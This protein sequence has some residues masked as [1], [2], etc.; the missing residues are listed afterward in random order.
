[1]EL[2]TAFRATVTFNRDVFIAGTATSIIIHFLLVDGQVMAVAVMLN[3]IAI[4]F[5]EIE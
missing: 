4:I 5:V 1:M 3:V 2:E